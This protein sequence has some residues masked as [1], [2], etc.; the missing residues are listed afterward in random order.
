M[1]KITV[2]QLFAVL[3]LLLLSACSSQS[4]Y[5][6]AQDSGYGYSEQ[7]ISDNYYRVS[8]KARGDDRGKA[9][10]YAMRRASELTQARGYDWFVIVQNDATTEREAPANQ[11]S[12]GYRQTTV[13]DC[14]LLTCRSR[15]VHEPDYSVSLSAGS[16]EQ[17]DVVLEIRMGKGVMPEN[18][19]AHPAHPV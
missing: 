13:H 4:A 11:I 18:A 6:A 17:V 14:G 3:S 8:F 15:T 19:D 16:R 2:T 10:T 7:Q 9:R 5:R 1:I 12:T